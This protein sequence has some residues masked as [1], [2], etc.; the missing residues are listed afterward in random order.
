[1]TRKNHCFIVIILCLQTIYNCIVSIIGQYIYAYFLK[2]YPDVNPPNSSNVTLWVREDFQLNEET[3]LQDNTSN[4][5]NS[6]Q[7]WAQQHS[8]D[9]IFRMT[10]WRAFPVIIMTYLFGLYASYLNRRLILFL[11][12]IGNAIHVVIYQAI[13]YK[14]LA[15]YWWYIAAFIAGFAGGTNVLSQSIFIV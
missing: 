9:L 14:N 11:S 15:L 4:P 6:A 8:A 10:L 13:I 1:M 12:I 5:N 7:I 2:T 3:C